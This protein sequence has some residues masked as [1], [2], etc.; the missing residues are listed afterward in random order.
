MNKS[1]LLWRKEITF[2]G[3]EDFKEPQ[4]TA[5]GNFSV[6]HNH[7][8]VW[9]RSRLGGGDPNHFYRPFDSQYPWAFNGTGSIIA[10]YRTVERL[11]AGFN[12]DPTWGNKYGIEMIWTIDW[13]GGP[14]E[15]IAA[16][17]RW[18]EGHIGIF[19]AVTCDSVWTSLGHYPSI[20][21]RMLYV[22]DIAGDGREEM[23]VYDASDGRIKVFWNP[24]ENP[25]QPRL[26]KWEDPLYKRL[27]QN[28]N[29]YSP[30]GYTYPDYPAVSNVQT[31]D[32]TASGATLTWQTD[33]AADSRVEFGTSPDLGDFSAFDAGLTTSHSIHI[34][35]LQQNTRHYFRVRSANANGM[36]GVSRIHELDLIELSP[37]TVT[38]LTLDASDHVTLNWQAMGQVSGYHVYRDTVPEVNIAAEN[39]V[40]SSVQGTEWTDPENVTGDPDTHYF[41][42][43]TAVSGL[44]E[45][46]P[47]D[48]YGEYDYPLIVSP[49]TDFNVVGIPVAMSGIATAS[50]LMNAIPG[51]NGVARW[52]AQNQGFE[53]YVPEYNINNFTVS[54]GQAVYVNVSSESVWTLTGRVAEPV[55]NLVTSGPSSFNQI[56][57]PLGRADLANASDL[58]ADIPNCN[59]VARWDA[60][61][62]G[63]SDQ[64]DPGI[65]GSDFPV[66]P[67]NAYL[68]NVTSSGTWPASSASEKRMIADQKPESLPESSR[69]PHLVWGRP[70][71]GLSGFRAFIAD[72][73]GDVLTR[74]SPGCRI[75][76]GV[77]AVQCG[78]FGAAWK[79]GEEVR[80][81]FLGAKGESLGRTRVVLTSNPSDAA[82][83]PAAVESGPR[84]PVHTAL[85]V[86]Y[87]NPFNPETMIPF[88]LAEDAY[89]EIRIFSLQGRR[90]RTLWSGEKPAGRHRIVWDGRDA[91]GKA[92]SGG[93]YLVRMTAGSF[94]RSRKIILIK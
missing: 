25:Y 10:T 75:G 70:V 89:V 24:A 68:V 85:G 35:T 48:V 65:P 90:V 50:A 31:T 69:A 54:E 88:A 60:A 39:R 86:N 19:D 77:W 44:Y 93:I 91:S 73:P 72:R 33:E 6:T 51:C 57:L 55:Y 13:T 15:H 23:I 16:K 78:N 17:A 29:Y 61:A 66:T 56:L 2:T 45:G 32:I 67:G 71:F 52:D 80:V 21:A 84:L 59:S 5:V 26:P 43:V 7:A 41:Y 38:G 42:K 82:A 9:V 1:G 53:Q 40:G 18:V 14:K 76:E 30:G 11:P 64:Y 87:P 34:D 58:C 63:Y 74:E 47:S 81:E 36:I 49:G 8:E 27:K 94:I 92:V 4:H 28:W 37:V 79:P 46:D 12:T 62:Q 20:Q 3:Y 22:A 83:D